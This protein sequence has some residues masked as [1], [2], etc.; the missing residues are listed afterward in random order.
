MALK[1]GGSLVV[2]KRGNVGTPDQ[3]MRSNRGLGASFIWDFATPSQ[4][5]QQFQFTFLW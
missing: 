1:W 2:D 4:K 5:W 3:R